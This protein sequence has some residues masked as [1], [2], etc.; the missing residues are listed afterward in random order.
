MLWLPLSADVSTTLPVLP[1]YLVVMIN[2]F[3]GLR[4]VLRYMSHATV[5]LMLPFFPPQQVVMIKL[6]AGAASCTL[7]VVVCRCT[8]DAVFPVSPPAGGHDQ[9]VRWR[10]I[11][12]SGVRRN[13]AHGRR[14]DASADSRHGQPAGWHGQRQRGV[15][16]RT[17]GGQ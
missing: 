13:D 2:L 17:K 16:A 6:F 5:Q 11:R 1:V 4:L 10:Y 12:S 7:A 14:E 3:A 9:L 8:A 15:S